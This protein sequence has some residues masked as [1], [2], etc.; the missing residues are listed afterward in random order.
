MTLL[1]SIGQWLQH[2]AEF[3]GIHGSWNL[4]VNPWLPKSSYFP[5]QRNYHFEDVRLMMTLRCWYHMVYF[6][7]DAL[8]RKLSPHRAMQDLHTH[9][10]IC[11]CTAIATLNSRILL[12]SDEGWVGTIPTK[13]LLVG[14]SVS[15]YLH[16]Y[17]GWWHT[18]WVD[19][20][21]PSSL[22]IRRSDVSI[23]LNHLSYLTLGLFVECKVFW[24]LFWTVVPIFYVDAGWK[25]AIHGSVCKRPAPRGFQ[26]K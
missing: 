10:E 25:S 23:C 5:K 26:G 13:F 2:D 6:R 9:V 8:L 4:N 7:K 22:H 24:N 19:E 15:Y 21:Q 18:Q 1:R 17:T 12:W 3:N 11:D 14:L 20:F 16:F